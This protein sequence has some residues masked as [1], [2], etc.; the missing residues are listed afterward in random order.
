VE[1]R[2]GHGQGKPTSKR[3]ESAV[4]L[5]GFLMDRFG[6]STTVAIP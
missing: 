2:A 4:D 5:Y 1:D 6:M 3:I